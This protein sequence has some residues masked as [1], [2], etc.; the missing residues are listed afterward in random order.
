MSLEDI[1]S[2]FGISI[3]QDAHVW[4]S[5]GSGNPIGSLS[6]L[7]SVCCVLNSI[8][9]RFIKAFFSITV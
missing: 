3:L 2:E 5:I 4:W 9:S 8:F 7:G 1:K 6:S